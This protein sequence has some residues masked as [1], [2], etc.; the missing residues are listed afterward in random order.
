MNNKRQTIW[1]V[2]M[3]SLMVILSAYYLFTEDVGT[4]SNM[5]TDGTKQEQGTASNATEASGKAADDNGITVSEVTGN[6]D[7]NA[8][9]DAAA[10]TN[11]KDSKDN[12]AATDK[13]TT[14]NAAAAAADEETLKQ[15][16]KSGAVSESVFSQMQEKRDQKYYDEYNK[17][18]A[19]ISDTKKDEKTAG[20]AVE[21]LN[22]LED[23]STKVTGLEEELTKQYSN[24][25]V[26][27]DDNNHYKVVVQS[28]KLERS[29]A[30]SILSMVI[31]ELG[32]SPDQVTI[33]YVK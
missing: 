31:N 21:Q 20:A 14:D 32:V 10:A 8:G 25:A 28:D 27:S 30:E 18:L 13:A 29:Q 23:K 16:E 11:T 22:L 26:V 24:A 19:S 7:A 9:T 2:S 12:A 33:Q 6:N 15:L 4:P 3:L 5:V 1:L 17:L